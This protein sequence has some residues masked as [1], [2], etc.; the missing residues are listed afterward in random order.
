MQNY[1]SYSDKLCYRYAEQTDLCKQ[2]NDR[3][4]G[5][6]GGWVYTVCID[7]STELPIH[8]L[9]YT[10]IIIES[11]KRSRVLLCAC[12]YVCKQPK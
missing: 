7:C 1:S 4:I 5:I 9:H 12:T 3:V 11:K 10:N 2:T 8:Q 6:E